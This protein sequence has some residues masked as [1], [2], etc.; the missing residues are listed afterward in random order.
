[1]WGLLAEV[2]ELGRIRLADRAA[3]AVA[4]VAVTLGRP[5]LAVLQPVKDSLVAHLFQTREVVVVAL[6]LSVLLEPLVL[7]ALEAQDWL[8]TF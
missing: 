1:M 5:P 6:V 4:L 8:Q 2:A 3:Q 7:V